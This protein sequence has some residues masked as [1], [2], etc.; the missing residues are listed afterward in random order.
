[1]FTYLSIVH[2]A[3][4]GAL[5]RAAIASGVG[6][7]VALGDHRLRGIVRLYTRVNDEITMKRKRKKREEKTEMN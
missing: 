4:F 6:I 2:V 3:N 7:T 5:R 1:V